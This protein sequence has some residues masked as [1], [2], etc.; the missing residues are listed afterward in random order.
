MILPYTG[1]HCTSVRITNARLV[2]SVYHGTLKLKVQLRW[3]ALHP[4]L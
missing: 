2:F 4:A 1:T 3:L